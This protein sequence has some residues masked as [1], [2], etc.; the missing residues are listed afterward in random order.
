MR[1]AIAERGETYLLMDRH[2]EALADL[3]RAI[4]LDDEDPWAIAERGA[5]YRRMGR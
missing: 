1:W 3:N 5:T 2:E 4:D